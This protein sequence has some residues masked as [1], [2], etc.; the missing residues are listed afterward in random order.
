MEGYRK[1]KLEK[2]LGESDLAQEKFAPADERY[3]KDTE[4]ID[5]IGEKN[6]VGAE[7][8]NPIC[9]RS[10]CLDTGDKSKRSPKTGAG[11]YRYGRG[12]S[13]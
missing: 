10:R 2:A 5:A 7:R 11:A 9:K 6:G 12:G 13:A 4:R 1:E 3:R 8:H